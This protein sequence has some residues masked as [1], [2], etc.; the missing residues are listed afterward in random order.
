MKFKAFD[1]RIS[2]AKEPYGTREKVL[3]EAKPT[4]RRHYKLFRLANPPTRAM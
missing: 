1:P 2:A 4:S 3:F